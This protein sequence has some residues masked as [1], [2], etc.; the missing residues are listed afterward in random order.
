MTLIPGQPVTLIPG[1]PVTLMP[2]NQPAYLIAH[3]EPAPSLWR[4]LLSFI[5]P[6]LSLLHNLFSLQQIIHRLSMELEALIQQ[7]KQGYAQGQGG[8]GP[9]GQDSVF[10][11]PARRRSQAGPQPPQRHAD[12][13]ATAGHSARQ[14]QQVVAG[15]PD[16]L[17]DLLFEED[18]DS[19]DVAR[20]GPGL[21][22]DAERAQQMKGWRQNIA[23]D[24][25]NGA[26]EMC[27]DIEE[28]LNFAAQDGKLPDASIAHYGQALS[29][30]DGVRLGADEGER[31]AQRGIKL[32]GK[33]FAVGL[34]VQDQGLR[35][36]DHGA[37]GPRGMSGVD[38]ATTAAGGDD[39]EI[40]F[41][42]KDHFDAETP[43][44][45]DGQGAAAHGDYDFSQETPV[46]WRDENGRMNVDRWGPSGRTSV[47]AFQL[48]G[49]VDE[50]GPLTPSARVAGTTTGREAPMS[51]TLQVGP[52][53][54]AVAGRKAGAER[55]SGSVFAEGQSN[56]ARAVANS[57]T[58]TERPSSKFGAG[59]IGKLKK[60]RSRI[61][62]KINLNNLFGK[63]KSSI[64]NVNVKNT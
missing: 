40:Y 48:G 21:G 5:C 36:A 19:T 3:P 14:P 30:L 53:S 45:H 13:A 35:Q 51:A 6:E 7:Q 58:Q 27:C 28:E 12:P 17:S 62:D 57:S 38:M 49:D 44:D 10:A 29:L 26:H 64:K 43:L 24:P 20:K 50:A 4:G 63:L 56:S 1:Q 2:G 18:P 9:S 60:Y 42:A 16:A 39:D 37:V 47:P 41:D 55:A 31:L 22:S 33:L 52:S 23:E 15:N 54:L 11:E 34:S 46:F 25:L 32:V 61:N 59:N 8:G